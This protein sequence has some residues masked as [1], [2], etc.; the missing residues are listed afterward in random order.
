MILF[1][2]V[3]TCCHLQFKVRRGDVSLRT[4]LKQFQNALRI[5]QFTLIMSTCRSAEAF[6][7]LFE[8]KLYHLCFSSCTNINNKPAFHVVIYTL[9][10][11][12]CSST[13]QLRHMHL[14]SLQILHSTHHE[15]I[16]IAK[17]NECVWYIPPLPPPP[18]NTTQV[19][20]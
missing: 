13:P 10:Y 15:L 5:S 2:S 8:I 3:L 19:F 16:D 1:F 18:T 4:R 17:G 9:L 6:C 12:N 11:H 7:L 20:L 14:Q